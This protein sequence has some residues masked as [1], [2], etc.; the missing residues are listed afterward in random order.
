M[1]KFLGIVKTL[2][3]KRVLTGGQGQSP[4]FFPFPYERT[5]PWQN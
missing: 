1:Q 3:S 5:K 2:F 4:S